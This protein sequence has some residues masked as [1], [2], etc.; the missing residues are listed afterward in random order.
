MASF[1]ADKSELYFVHHKRGYGQTYSTPAT[2]TLTISGVP[3]PEDTIGLAQSG[4]SSWLTI[5]VNCEHGE[6]FDVAIARANLPSDAS[7]DHTTLTATITA[8]YGGY[9]DLEI[10]VVLRVRD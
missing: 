1:T 6:A 9:D 3:D 4:S 5:P 2:Q 7:G 8:S 10:P